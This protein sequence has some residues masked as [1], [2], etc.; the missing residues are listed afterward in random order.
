MLVLIH[1]S[2]AFLVLW[3][4][5]WLICTLKRCLILEQSSET[6]QATTTFCHVVSK[7][8]APFSISLDQMQS[9]PPDSFEPFSD[10]IR[11]SVSGEIGFSRNSSCIQSWACFKDGKTGKKYNWTKH[12]LLFLLLLPPLSFWVIFDNSSYLKNLKLIYILL[13]FI[14]SLNKI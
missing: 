4:L 3:I 6:K 10:Y 13:W 14:L 1:Y 7:Y 2:A 8:K 12:R 5:Y 9:W 11:S